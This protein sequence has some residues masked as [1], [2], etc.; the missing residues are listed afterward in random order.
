MLLKRKSGEN[1]RTWSRRLAK[2]CKPE[3]RVQMMRIGKVKPEL[4]LQRQ[5]III[6][7]LIVHTYIKL[8]QAAGQDK[9]HDVEQRTRQAAADARENFDSY[10]HSAQKAASNARDSTENLYKEARTAT[11][12][13]IDETRSNIEKKGEEAKSGWF[14]WLGWG[15][16][17]AEETKQD[18]AGKVADSAEDVKKQAEKHV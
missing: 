1:S 4:T 12:R 2:Q 6:Q 7:G 8:S 10:R 3:R 15:K 18:V 11:D 14:S 16:S 17:K 5:G 9:I 13:K